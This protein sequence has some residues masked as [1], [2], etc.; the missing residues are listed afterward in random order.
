MRVAISQIIAVVLCTGCAIN[1][2]ALSVEEVGRQP[3]PLTVES[4]CYRG[5]KIANTQGADP[6]L[7]EHNTF[8]ALYG[9]EFGVLVLNVTANLPDREPLCRMVWIEIP[10]I[11][12]RVFE[13]SETLFW[14]CSCDWRCS[15][16]KAAKGKVELIVPMEDGGFVAKVSVRATG[17]SF[18][19]NM[20]NE[21]DAEQP[22]AE[23]VDR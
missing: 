3:S 6:K 5:W 14:Q 13:A 21:F 22:P 11:H 17:F 20:N 10:L 4:V 19:S 7:A 18:S 8:D 12:S 1:T 9:R 2:P 23:Y 15:N 16:A